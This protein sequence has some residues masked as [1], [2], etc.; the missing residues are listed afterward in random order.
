MVA[1]ASES[2]VPTQGRAT[3][4]LGWASANLDDL[5]ETLRLNNVEF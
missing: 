2:L 3:D 5:E 1:Q 4:H